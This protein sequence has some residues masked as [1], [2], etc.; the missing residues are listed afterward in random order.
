MLRNI[1]GGGEDWL[2]KKVSGKLLRGNGSLIKGKLLKG[3]G[4]SSFN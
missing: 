3:K 1:F 2:N 4:H